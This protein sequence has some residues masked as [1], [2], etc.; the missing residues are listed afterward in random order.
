L[1]VTGLDEYDIK[2]WWGLKAVFLNYVQQNIKYITK[3]ACIY[4]Y[5]HIH[6]LDYFKVLSENAINKIS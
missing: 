4:I 6:N 5:I 3:N 2:Y 1:N